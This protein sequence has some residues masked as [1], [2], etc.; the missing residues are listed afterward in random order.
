MGQ[1]SKSWLQ[2]FGFAKTGTL[3]SL[4]LSFNIFASRAYLVSRLEV[5]KE[6]GLGAILDFNFK[7]FGTSAPSF[8][9]TW[10]EVTTDGCDT[11]IFRLNTTTFLPV[12]SLFWDFLKL[13]FRLIS[14]DFKLLFFCCLPKN[15]W[16]LFNR[17]CS[18]SS[19][20]VSSSDVIELCL[21]WAFWTF[22]AF[23]TTQAFMKWRKLV[24]D[25]KGWKWMKLDVCKMH[26]KNLDECFW[27]V[28]VWSSQFRDLVV[29]LKLTVL[30]SSPCQ[31]TKNIVFNVF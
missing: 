20:T 31:K 7:F 28:F 18:I 8:W 26:E 29:L 30:W 16:I 25:W 6:G 23:Q 13:D 22:V 24:L 10:K 15:A 12:L 27:S 14:V 9:T 2:K 21:E 1:P 5:E 3:R 4:P 11:A 19:C 17:A